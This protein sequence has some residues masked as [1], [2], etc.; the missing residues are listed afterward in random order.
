MP[1]HGMAGTETEN[2][3]NNFLNNHLPRRFAATT[4]LAIDAEDNISQQCDTLIYDAENNPI[5]RAGD[6]FVA[7]IL[8]SDSI[9]A[10]I[11]IKSNLNKNE[12]EDAAKKL[13]A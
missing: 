13:A 7:Q 2:I 11:E 8:P 12:L 3:L 6:N 4:G 1:H 9:A 5:Y 10:A